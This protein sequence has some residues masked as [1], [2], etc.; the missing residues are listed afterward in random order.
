MAKPTTS[1]SYSNT[2]YNQ[3]SFFGGSLPKTLEPPVILQSGP[4]LEFKKDVGLGLAIASTFGCLA[5]SAHPLGFADKVR[6]RET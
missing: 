1:R 5:M 2:I 6:G 4:M 3:R